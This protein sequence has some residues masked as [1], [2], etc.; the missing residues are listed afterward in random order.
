MF[1]TRGP[2][3]CR[4]I[5]I[6]CGKVCGMDPSQVGSLNFGETQHRLGLIFPGFGLVLSSVVVG[7]ALVS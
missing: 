4:G 6:S 7:V 5:G 2:G 1:Q 3:E